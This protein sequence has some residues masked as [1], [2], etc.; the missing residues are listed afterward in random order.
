M[1][2]D[3]LLE[4]IIYL[5]NHE[6]VTASVLAERFHVT[7]RTIQRDMVCITE[8]GIPVYSNHGKNGGYS[9]LPSYKMKNCDIRKDEQQ[10]IRKALESLATS[11]ANETLA[12]LIEKYHAVLGNTGDQRI[13][14]DFGI[15]RENQK[16][17]QDNLALE[18]AIA[19][20][21]LVT[22][23]YRDA[24]GRETQRL[25][26]PLAIQYKWYSWYLFAW[27]VPQKAYRTFKIARILDLRVTSKRSDKKHPDVGLLMKEADQA[28][29]DT[30]ITIEVHFMGK[31]K[32]V[33]EEYFP[34]SRI[35]ELSGE[36]SRVWIQVPPGERLWKAL[37]LSLGNQVEVISP[38][39]YRNELIETAQN[40]LSNYDI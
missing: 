7:V 31:I 11:Y 25:V 29:S 14:F 24:E 18:Q 6:N 35:E 1:K 32:G 15:A 16:V 13:F 34:D 21:N 30:C 37:L 28:Y 20:E 2:I 27:S 8:A 10:I 19:G 4:I 3:R 38:E 39:I 26:Q 5:L 22:F 12:G 23:L 40:F 17:Q 33:I 9:I 36:K